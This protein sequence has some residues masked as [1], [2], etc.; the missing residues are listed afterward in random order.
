MSRAV[1]NA[2]MKFLIEEVEF[3]TIYQNLSSELKSVAKNYFG[4]SKQ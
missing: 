2:D 4:L 1:T 3:R